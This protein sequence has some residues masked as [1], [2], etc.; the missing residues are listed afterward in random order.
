MKYPRNDGTR[1]EQ[2]NTTGTLEHPLNDGTLPEKSK[3]CGT[4][5]HY[6]TALAE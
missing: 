5:E 1:L 6:D 4:V 2:H 3:D